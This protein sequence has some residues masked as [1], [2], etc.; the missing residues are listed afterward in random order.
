MVV[1]STPTSLAPGTL[2]TLGACRQRHH[3]DEEVAL[4]DGGAGV[5]RVVEDDNLGPWIEVL[6]HRGDGGEEAVGLG[7]V[8]TEDVARGQRD[9]VDVD[10][11]RRRRHDGRVAGAHQRQAHVAE[12]FL[13]AEPGE[14]LRLRVEADAV[15][16][17]VAQGHLTAQVRQAVGHGV[18]MA[19]LVLG[20]LAELVD[21]RWIRGVGGVAHAEIDDV[22]ASAALGIF[23]S[24]DLAEEVGRQ[25]L[26]AVGD[27]DLEGVRLALHGGGSQEGRFSVSL[28]RPGPPV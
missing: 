16:P 11:E 3:F 7:A 5:V 18:P 25:A 10:G 6:R 26:D 15:Q 23:Q 20:R 4:D 1:V 9:G 17:G 2:R 13:R 21:H 12:D 19:L 28:A 27:V 14:D 24:V 22:D 8:E